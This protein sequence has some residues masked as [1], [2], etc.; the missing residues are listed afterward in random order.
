MRQPRKYGPV[1]S[2]I[3]GLLSKKP[4]GFNEILRALKSKKIV[5]SG[6][7][8][9]PCLEQ[10][11]E[12]GKIEREIIREKPPKI[13]EYKLAEHPPYPSEA[14]FRRLKEHVTVSDSVTVTLT[15]VKTGEK[16]TLILGKDGQWIPV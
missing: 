7:T 6:S 3:T 10:L 13:V 14:S 16:R 5:G 15:D 8:L 1:S 4:M 11:K 12:E 2:A 9:A